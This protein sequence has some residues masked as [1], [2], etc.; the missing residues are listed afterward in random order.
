MRAI[1]V[2]TLNDGQEVGYDSLIVATGAKNHYFGNDQWA[3][4]LPG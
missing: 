3:R 4:L 2:L 1:A